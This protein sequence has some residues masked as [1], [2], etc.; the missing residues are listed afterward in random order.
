MVLLDVQNLR[1]YFTTM[2]GRVKAVDGIN[3]DVEL[4][5]ATGLAGES[6]CGKTTTALSILRILPPNGKI[7]GGKILFKN[8]DIVTLDDDEIREEIRWK[9][10]SIVFQGAMNALNPVYSVGHQM[11]EAIRLHEPEVDEREAWERSEKLMELVG[12]EP[13]RLSGYPHEF[14]GGMKQRSM[15]A[16]A[17]VC[18]PSL[19]IADE[20][21]TA[22]DVI[23]AAQVLKLMKELKTRL[24]LGMILITHD[25]SIIAEICERVAIMYAGKIGEYGDIVT[26]FKEPLHPYTQGLIGAFPDITAERTR[27]ISIPGYPPDLLNPPK[28]CRFHARCKY[29]MDVCQKDEPL[30][31]ELKKD[32]WVACHLY[33]EG[34]VQ[35]Q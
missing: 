23:V 12:V 6:G 29:A 35:K 1:T 18:N 32:H 16:M 13:S 21:S 30:S 8:K 7:V 28:G 15:I 17:L 24:N 26:V 11:V 33:S 19:L 10:I 31:C 25:L 22:L 5:K 3:F 2:S 27:M 20:P 34:K 9:E 4:G 14:S